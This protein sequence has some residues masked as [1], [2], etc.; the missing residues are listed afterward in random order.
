LYLGV[1][2]A[3]R[4][5][6]LFASM[7]KEFGID[8]HEKEHKVVVEKEPENNAYAAELRRLQVGDA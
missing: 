4:E 6:Q 7:L 3:E 5:R 8:L 1:V 2:L